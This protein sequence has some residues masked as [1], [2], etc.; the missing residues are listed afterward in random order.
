MTALCLIMHRRADI[1]HKCIIFKCCNKKYIPYTVY[2]TG[3]YDVVACGI[4]V[5]NCSSSNIKHILPL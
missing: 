4:T 5:Y 3:A 1:A 2:C